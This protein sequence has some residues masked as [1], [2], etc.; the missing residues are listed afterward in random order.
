MPRPTA[1]SRCRRRT[2]PAAS[3]SS[4][5]QR[6]LLPEVEARGAKGAAAK[7]TAYLDKYAAA[8]GARSSELAQTE[9]RKTVGG[10]TVDFAQ[11]YRGVPVFAGELL[12]HVDK[13][14][15]LTSVNGFAVPDLDLAVTPALSKSD[16]STRAVDLVRNAPK[17]PRGAKDGAAAGVRAAS[18]DLMV[19]RMGSTRGV[20][21]DALLAYVVEVTNERTVRETVIVDALTGKPVNRYSMIAHATDRE[22]YEEALDPANRCGRRATR[23]PAASTRTRPARCRAPV[24]RTGCSRTP[25]VATP[26]T[27]PGPR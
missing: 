5:P 2:R 8:F 4:A 1:R 9:V 17:L 23:S 18:T 20:D 3:A 13:E 14:G 26:T 19:Y 25:S 15:D 22:L 7:A 6:D 21:G 27:A 24:R 10:W 12:A 11:S 16:A